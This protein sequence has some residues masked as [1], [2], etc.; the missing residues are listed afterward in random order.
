MQGHTK[1]TLSNTD[2]KLLK[3]AG[4]VAALE[5]EDDAFL[6]AV[7]NLVR[8]T[9]GPSTTDVSDVHARIFTRLFA[10]PKKGRL[11]VFHFLNLLRSTEG[12]VPLD[13]LAGTDALDDFFE[14]G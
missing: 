8:K 1:M 13:D 12:K 4:V 2:R 3:W 7:R 9:E 6:E 11:L 10:D 5:E 14:A